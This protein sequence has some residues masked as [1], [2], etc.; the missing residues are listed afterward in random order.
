MGHLQ[1]RD[2][3]DFDDETATAVMKD[4][5]AAKLIA[6]SRDDDTAPRF[7]ETTKVAKIPVAEIFAAAGLAPV[8]LPAAS[9]RAPGLHLTWRRAAVFVLAAALV[10]VIAVVVGRSFGTR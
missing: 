1:R 7:D 4:D 5:L 8:D 3:R 9:A 10:A 6:R 2:Q